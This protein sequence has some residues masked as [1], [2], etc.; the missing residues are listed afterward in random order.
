MHCSSTGSS[1]DT[2]SLDRHTEPD[3]VATV[4]DPEP[5]PDPEPVKRRFRPRNA[6]TNSV[7]CGAAAVSVPSLTVAAFAHDADMI[8]S[9]TSAGRRDARMAARVPS[10]LGDD[11]AAAAAKRPMAC[12]SGAQ[13]DERSDEVA[14]RMACW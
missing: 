1:A 9:A 10:L 11:D 12:C 6:A 7:F 5:D 14:A 8:K 3:D 2:C 13:R 4:P